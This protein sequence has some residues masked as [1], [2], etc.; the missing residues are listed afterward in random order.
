MVLIW[1]RVKDALEARIFLGICVQGLWE[2]FA[3]RGRR[4]LRGVRS[5]EKMDFG[6]LCDPF[7][8]E[9]CNVFP[10]I[11]VRP[12]WGLLKWGLNMFFEIGFILVFVI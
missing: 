5:A 11:N 3:G 2:G 9:Y 4:V 7:G 12:L 1:V 6:L 8:V 10:A